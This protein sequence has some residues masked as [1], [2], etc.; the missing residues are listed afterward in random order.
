M[1]ALNNFRR[2]VDA[3]CVGGGNG[4]KPCRPNFTWARGQAGQGSSLLFLWGGKLQIPGSNPG[5]PAF[6]ETFYNVVSYSLTVPRWCRPVKEPNLRRYHAGL[7]TLV[8]KACDAGSNPARGT[9]R[10]SCR[11]N[12][13]R[14]WS[15]SYRKSARSTVRSTARRTRRDVSFIASLGK[16]F[17]AGVP[18]PGLKGRGGNDRCQT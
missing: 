16:V 5:G 14:S 10:C 6:Q 18:E 11:G 8:G 15:K 9:R 4:H 3:I 2:F 13:R 7:S 1:C 12:Q 17:L